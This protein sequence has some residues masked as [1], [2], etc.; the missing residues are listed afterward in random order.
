MTPPTRVVTISASY[1][2][3]G[4][5]VGPMVAQRLGLPFVDR[6]IPASVAARLDVPLEDALSHDERAASGF[7]RALS[8]VALAGP[9]PDTAGALH[10]DTANR[11]QAQTEAVIREV[12]DHTGGVVLGRAAAIVLGARSDVL[13]VRL[14]GPV[15]DR[16]R[17]AVRMGEPDEATAG[18]HVRAF[19][20]AWDGY[21]KRFYRTDATDPRHYDLVINSTSLKLE[22]CA[23]LIALAAISGR[24]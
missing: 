1:G 22:V 9:M 6:A 23:E 12:A 20:R 3:G 11:F 19:D 14:D 15:E 5:V 4:S 16:I 7:W 2:A 13:R 24:R 8:T 21:V 18:D 10:E 17:Q